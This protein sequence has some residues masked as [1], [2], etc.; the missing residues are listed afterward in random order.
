VSTGSERSAA[1]LVL[2]SVLL[3]LA[4]P[5]GR[6]RAAIV[7]EIVARVNNR[8]ITK[9]EFEERGQFIL[10]DLYQKHSGAE[11]D[12]HLQAAED[13]LLA[14][15][16]TELLLVERA[17]TL[18]DLEKV[19]EGLI[20]DFRKQQN[21]ESDEELERLLA[22]QGLTRKDLEEQLIR[23][24]VPQEIVNYDVKRKIS[25]SEREIS[26]YYDGHPEKYET[27][28][29]VT[30]REIVLFYEDGGR[31]AALA[32]AAAIQE[33]SSNGVDFI[34]LIE[35]YSEAGSKEAGGLLGPLTMADL[36]PVI[37][38]VISSMEIEQVSDPIDT[39]RSIHLVRLVDRTSKIVTPIEDV[40]EEISN[41]ILQQK[42]KP[43]FERYVRKLWKDS[44][45]KI[46]PKYE[47]FLVVSPINPNGRPEVEE[48]E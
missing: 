20:A 5:L 2:L 25:V 35:R 41:V 26:E 15:L 38:R 29:T 44:Y 6:A 48:S 28:L 19:R 14:N 21:I 37:G 30:F 4:L 22:D 9:S 1:L 10:Q 7:E 32:R 31:S 40:R 34:D 33:E 11:L 47:R 43:R 16:I 24:A 36:N 18:F 45:V 8:I 39:G 46:A 3:T 13:T 27:P 23:L 17:Q 42:F 12:R